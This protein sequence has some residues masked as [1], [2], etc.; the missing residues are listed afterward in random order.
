[1]GDHTELVDCLN[2]LKAT[3]AKL[4]EICKQAYS[5]GNPYGLSPKTLVA[6]KTVIADAQEGE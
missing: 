1:M 6:L 4:L 2:H 3:N 5:D